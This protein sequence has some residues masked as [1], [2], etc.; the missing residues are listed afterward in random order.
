MLKPGASRGLTPALPGREGPAARWGWARLAR[1]VRAAGNLSA[2][3]RGNYCPVQPPQP[4]LPAAVEHPGEEDDGQ[5]EIE[6]GGGE[7][8]RHAPH[9]EAGGARVNPIRE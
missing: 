1:R 3:N 7:P 6:P 9:R 5:G 8:P 4:S 2:F